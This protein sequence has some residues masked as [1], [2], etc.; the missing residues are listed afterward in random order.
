MHKEELISLHTML[1]NVREY[2]QKQNSEAD[3]NE[4]DALEITPSQTHRSKVEHKYAIFVLGNAI[5]KAM[6]EIDNPS[7]AR[8]ADRM[9][10]LAERT[11][12]E[13]EMEG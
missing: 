12:K 6:K 11:L 7:A 3:F 1:M 2:L 9:H 4:Y 10:E 13:I 8:M 5:A